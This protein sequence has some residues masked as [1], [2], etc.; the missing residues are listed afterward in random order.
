MQTCA[1]ARQQRCGEDLSVCV[2]RS[3]ELFRKVY[4]EIPKCNFD[5]LKKMNSNSVFS[6]FIRVRIGISHMYI[7]LM[8][9]CECVNDLQ[10]SR[11]AIATNPILVVR[12]VLLEG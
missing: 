11:L 10:G 2:L 1:L 8:I 7:G 5:V 3:S 9:G 4:K 6:C 12:E